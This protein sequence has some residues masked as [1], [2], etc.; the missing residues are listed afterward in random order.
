MKLGDLWRT[1]LDCVK[2][3]VTFTLHTSTPAVVH[4]TKHETSN[5]RSSREEPNTTADCGK[6]CGLASNALVG[7]V[8]TLLC[9]LICRIHR[10]HISSENVRLDTKQKYES[11]GKSEATLKAKENIH[12]NCM[13][14][15]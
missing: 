5:K 11:K 1:S 12:Q 3:S 10:I 15:G 2:N 6:Y 14:R 9:L 13:W 7:I 8:L 4:F